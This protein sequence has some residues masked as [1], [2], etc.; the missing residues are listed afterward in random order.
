MHKT[1]KTKDPII[2]FE[3]TIERNPIIYILIDGVRD[4]GIQTIGDPHLGRKFKTG[5]PIHRLGEREQTVK[6]S[7]NDLLN[8]T[9]SLI[10]YV[11]VMGDLFDKF[12]V[13]P[14][15]VQFAYNQLFE[16]SQK[17]KNVMYSVLPG[18]HDLSK[19][20]S[21]VSSF[22][23][24]AQLCSLSSRLGF[25]GYLS[26]LVFIPLEATILLPIIVG[27]KYQVNLLL[28][29]Y[30][31][32]SANSI[33]NQHLK[34]I[35]EWPTISF[36]HYDSITYDGAG[37]LPCEGILDNSDLVVSGHEH[38]Y[39]YHRYDG[40][41]TPVVFTGSMQPYSHA[42]DPDGF[43]YKTIQDKDLLTLDFKTVVNNC[44]RIV[45]DHTFALKAPIDCFA[46]SF[47]LRDAIIPVASDSLVNVNTDRL[48]KYLM[49]EYKDHPNYEKYLSILMN[50]EF[51]T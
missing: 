41:K 40:S 48:I 12:I 26:T 51:I 30:S 43:I 20:I 29:S 33:N 23:L 32:F 18:N 8:P 2:T 28:D 42:E 47:K 46:L 11:I 45:C 3:V 37:Y 24:F 49:T 50:K 39:K 35:K 34:T 5:V 25:E 44:V 16:A 17:N 22:E 21:K 4:C 31:P 13:S 36:G 9:D 19:D 14:T 15:D 7:F 27:D 1:I 38:S 10:K 6:Q